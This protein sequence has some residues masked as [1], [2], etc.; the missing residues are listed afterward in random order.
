M[1]QLEGSKKLEQFAAY[2]SSTVSVIP[3]APFICA[4]KNSTMDDDRTT[5][6]MNGCNVYRLFLNE[7][8]LPLPS[9]EINA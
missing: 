1:K 7:I 2:F 6:S 5:S 8:R 3:K 4:E 9:G